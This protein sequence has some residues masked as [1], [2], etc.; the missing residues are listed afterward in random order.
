[1]IGESGR[2]RKDDGRR[3]LNSD[4]RRAIDPQSGKALALERHYRFDPLSH[5][6][7][8]HLTRF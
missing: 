8:R 3:G 6:N 2:D 7:T 5:R 1:M 4:Q